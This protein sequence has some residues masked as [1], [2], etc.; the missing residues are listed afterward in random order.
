MIK[1]LSVMTKSDIEL[2]TLILYH[3]LNKKGFYFMIR[4]NLARYKNGDIVVN[5]FVQYF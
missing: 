4:F 5:Y 2:L 3:V 1:N